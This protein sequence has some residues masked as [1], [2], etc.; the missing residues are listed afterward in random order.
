VAIVTGVNS[1]AIRGELDRR[2]LFA[3]KVS[4]YIKE[5]EAHCG[6]QSLV[7]TDLI[8]SAAVCKVVRNL[9]LDR[10]MKRGPFDDADE[11]LAA[12]RA[13]RTADSDLREVLRGL[14]LRKVEK[15]EDLTSYLDRTYGKGSKWQES[16]FLSL[17]AGP[18]A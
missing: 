11:A 16:V 1:R 4:E 17:P 14:P 6:E 7:L 3:R 2:Y 5:Y 8:H 15:Q 18:P 9:A 12:Y 13:F 10:L